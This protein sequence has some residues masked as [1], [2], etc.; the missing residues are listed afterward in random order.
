MT[1]HKQLI[2]FIA[3]ARVNTWAGD[4]GKGP[5]KRDGSE[6]VYVYAENDLRYMDEYFGAKRFQGQEIVY[7]VD[8]PIWGMVYYG[9]IPAGIDVD[10]DAEFAFLKKALLKESTRA[11]LPGIIEYLA[12]DHAYYCETNGDISDFQGE[13]IIKAKGQITHQMWFAGGSILP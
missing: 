10:A 2:K 9:G 1:N 7:Q 13:E 4:L 11:R 5:A 12:G 6:G 3:K 8:Q